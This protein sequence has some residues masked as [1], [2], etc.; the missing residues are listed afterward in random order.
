MNA[1]KSQLID[2]ED[3]NRAYRELHQVHY[4]TGGTGKMIGYG[5]FVLKL[6]SMLT[7]VCVDKEGRKTIL[8]YLP[9]GRPPRLK[10]G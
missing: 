6:F 8:R 7:T 9:E 10:D 2:W 5:A 3:I 1:K 4:L